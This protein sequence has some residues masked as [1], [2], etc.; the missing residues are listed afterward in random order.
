MAG[1]L[2]D[3]TPVNHREL[4]DYT[5]EELLTVGEQ[6]H[7]QRQWPFNARDAFADKES[8]RCGLPIRF[9]I[10]RN[11]DIAID[12]QTKIIFRYDMAIEYVIDKTTMYDNGVAYGVYL[13]RKK[14]LTAEEKEA[15]RRFHSH[16]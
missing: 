7:K 15:H 13:L 5:I 12:I 10:A 6:Y 14:H 1:R 16:A 11:L 9:R 3:Q 8:M 2:G 4:K